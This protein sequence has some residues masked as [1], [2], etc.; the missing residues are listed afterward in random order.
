MIDIDAWELN[1]LETA[2]IKTNI[3]KY[4]FWGIIVTYFEGII[5]IIF[6]RSL[7]QLCI[8]IYNISYPIKF[9]KMHRIWSI[10]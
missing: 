3:R 8:Y 4:G 7:N 9:C 5:F 2:V 6:S 10:K 1:K